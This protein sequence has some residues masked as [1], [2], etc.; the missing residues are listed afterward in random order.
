VKI[1]DAV[2]IDW[3]G[4]VWNGYVFAPCTNPSYVYVDV[5]F[6]DDPVLMFVQVDRDACP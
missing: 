1:G 4:R 6:G 5:M 2:R 3:A